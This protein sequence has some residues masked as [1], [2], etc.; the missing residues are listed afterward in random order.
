MIP[1]AKHSGW[2]GDTDLADWRDAGLPGADRSQVAAALPAALQC[3]LPVH[4]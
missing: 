2:P 4:G 3:L 1:T